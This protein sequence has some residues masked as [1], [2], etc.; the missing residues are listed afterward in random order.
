MVVADTFNAPC[1]TAP[2]TITFAHLLKYRFYSNVD[3]YNMECLKKFY[4]SNSAVLL[5]L[6]QNLLRDDIFI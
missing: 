4:S 3:Y 5:K 1:R 2:W 6:C